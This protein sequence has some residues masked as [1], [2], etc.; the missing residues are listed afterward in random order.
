MEGYVADLC[1]RCLVWMPLYA[2]SA[3]PV[4]LGGSAG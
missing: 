1:L 2:T 4:S 3:R